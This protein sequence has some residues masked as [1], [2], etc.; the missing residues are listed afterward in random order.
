VRFVGR[1]DTSDPA[2]PKIG[3]TGARILARFDG[4]QVSASFA[5]SSLHAADWGPSRFDV[6]VDGALQPS[7]LVLSEG[8]ATYPLASG[9]APGVHT[10][11][12]WKR[13]EANV[14]DVQFLGFD[15]AGGTLLPPPPA[16]TRRLEFLGD[17]A[18]NGYGVEGAGP[19][20]SFT[21]ATEN[22]HVAY[23][24]L[25]A[26]ALGAD[27]H[28]LSW[29]GRGV[30]W[31]NDRAGDP[32]VFA[33][34][35]PRTLPLVPG[36]TFDFT[37]FVPDVVWITLGG[38]DWDQ[39]NPGDPPPDPAAFE[40]KYAELVTLVRSKR[41]SAHVVCAVASSLNDDYPPG[42]LAYTH[43]KTALGDVVA[44]RNAAG[45]AKIYV[46]EF[47]RASPSDLTGCE[48]HPNVQKQ[49]AMADEAV[50]FIKAKTGWL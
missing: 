10:I 17:S 5:E 36:S 11:E 23:P 6:L 1:F 7:P 4:T 13:T 43:V 19:G 9:L 31:N 30:L 2:G 14:G 50:A 15:F 8:V 20:C 12:L 38:N 24:A 33:V 34:V 18:S 16:P 29:S 42:Y 26:L 41:P 46:F 49:K 37:S 27:H 35:Y 25:V 22:E 48:S 45:D 44:A 21:A 32:D 3:W 47:A 40:A 28:D 39:P